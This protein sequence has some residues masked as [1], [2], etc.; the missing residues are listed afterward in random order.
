[1]HAASDV[2]LLQK[3]QSELPLVCV[4]CQRCPCGHGGCLRV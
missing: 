4:P 3:R 2:T 1:L